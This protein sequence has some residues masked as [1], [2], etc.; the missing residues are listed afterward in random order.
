MDEREFL[1]KIRTLQESNNKISLTDFPV[2]RVK[3]KKNNIALL[4]ESEA[5]LLLKEDVQTLE[6][7]E[8]KEEEKTMVY[9]CK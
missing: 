8:Q 4:M 3:N 1:K 5:S 7:Q 2:N 9:I 6:A